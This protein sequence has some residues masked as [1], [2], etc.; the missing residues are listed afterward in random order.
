LRQDKENNL[1][2]LKA[3]TSGLNISDCLGVL[4]RFDRFHHLGIKPGIEGY[5]NPSS[6]NYMKSPF[7]FPWERDLLAEAVMCYGSH[8]STTSFLNKDLFLKSLQCARDYS[9]SSPYNFED[10]DPWSYMSALLYQQLLDQKPIDS[11]ELMIYYNIYDDSNIRKVI[12]G[13]FNDTLESLFKHIFL[14]YAIYIDRIFIKLPIKSEGFNFNKALFFDIMK[15][16][17]ADIEC[18]RNYSKNNRLLS[19]RSK[20]RISSFVSKPIVKVNISGEQ[21]WAPFT[22]H[23]LRR[24]TSGLYYDLINNKDFSN[25]IGHAFESY[26]G[27]VIRKI[28]P[29]TWEYEREI[30]IKGRQR[31]AS[32]DWI[33]SDGNHSVF[34]ECK[35]K[36]PI[37]VTK[38]EPDNKSS[39]NDDLRFYAKFC[40]QAI[41]AAERDLLGQFGRRFPDNSNF[42]IIVTSEDWLILNGA[43][44]A[45]IKEYCSNE[46]AEK[47]FD[48]ELY[49]KY[50]IINMGVKSFELFLQAAK[51][52]GLDDLLNSH[53]EKP[54]I[55]DY[56]PGFIAHNYRKDKKFS[57]VSIWA[58]EFSQLVDMN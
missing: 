53:A 4:G 50:I 14:I 35:Y 2:D 55:N 16:I 31:K 1:S 51:H 57:P 15:R 8:L 49:N 12:E 10:V 30:I 47:G 25:S 5:P 28:A 6:R 37:L 13:E 26:V 46:L 34:I 32:V 3:A 40:A 33:L 19:D 44:G 42:I 7:G 58:E 11:S 56:T 52:Y 41:I 54:H 24:L 27:K 43:R 39:L 36:R 45:I 20:F 21:Y 22:G 18:H 29:D 23:L 38:T 17:S 9:F 48:P